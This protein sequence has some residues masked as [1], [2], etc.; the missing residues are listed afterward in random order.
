VSITPTIVYTDGA[1]QGNPGPGGWAW[2]VPDGEFRS[3][4]DPATT[5]Q[6]MELLAVLD[7]VTNLRDP[8][9]IRSD[10]TYVVNCFKNRWWQGWKR[11]GWRTSQGQPVANRDLWEP[12][13]DEYLADPDRLSFQWVKG[14]SG[15]RMNDIVDRLAV[16]AASRQEGRSGRGTPDDLG[17]ADR[18][19]GPRRSDAFARGV[20]DRDDSA[21]SAALPPGHRLLVTGLRPPGLGGYDE[22]PVAASVRHRLAEILRAKA[23]M[24]PDL[25][26]TSGLGLGA[27]QL[28]VEAAI[29]AGVPYVAVLAF[30][31][32]DRMWPA[33]SR[34]RFAR[35]VDA[36][37]GAVVLDGTRPA[38]KQA[39]G[40]AL[41]RREEW[42]ADNADEALVVWDDEDS[43]VGRTVRDLQ[44][45]LGEEQVWVLQP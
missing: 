8:V 29:A 36:A 16:E 7:A 34:A 2:A 6:R 45:R 13:I 18:P 11:K 26:V 33:P 27:E 43:Q 12:L 39:A 5:N 4:A 28:G 31:E 37:T 10:S 15:E 30:D 38:D 22:N 41:A 32:Q 9:V 25:V 35:L 20:G 40:R 19:V 1:C 24:H 14:H 44:R 23:A 17:T 21:G 3:G 42:L